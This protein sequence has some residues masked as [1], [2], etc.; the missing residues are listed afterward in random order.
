M[1]RNK[2]ILVGAGCEDGLITVRGLETL[3]KADAV[4]YDSLV[5]PS[6]L[7]E[8]KKDCKLILSAS[9]RVFTAKVRTK[10]TAFF[11]TAEK[12]FR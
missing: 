3:R 12:K 8:C 10:S 9:E 5:S 2:V 6:L 11:V 7:S 1:S 4:V